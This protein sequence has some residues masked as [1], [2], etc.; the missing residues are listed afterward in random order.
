MTIAQVKV[1]E[2]VANEVINKNEEVY[3]KEAPLAVAK[4]IQGVRAMFDETYPDPVRVVSIGIPVE[5]MESNPT[6]PAGTLTSVEFCGGT[7]LKRAG[8]MGNFVVASEEAIAKGIRRIIALTGPEA[9]KAN[10][11]AELLC[12]RFDNVKGIIEDPKCARSQKEMVKLITD[13]TDDISAATISYWRKDELRT[14]LKGK[15]RIGGQLNG[16][17]TANHFH[18]NIKCLL[19]LVRIEENN[20]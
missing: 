11:K 20:R 15:V 5:K 4:T 8:H 1:T 2:E 9:D 19:I 13:L 14:K 3:A 18:R 17:F 7:H 12:K 6:E 10:G 16:T